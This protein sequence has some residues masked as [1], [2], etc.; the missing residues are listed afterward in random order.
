[1][2][3]SI[4]LAAF[5]V[6][7][8]MALTG[9]N[10]NTEPRLNPMP[11]GDEFI[12]YTPAENNYTYDLTNPDNTIILT[13]SGQ[14]DYGVAV[15]TSYEVQVSL[16]NTWEEGEKDENGDY[17]VYPTYY[18]L[19]TVNTQ[20]MVTASAL[21]LNQAITYLQGIYNED[22][23]NDYDSSVRPLWV[24]VLAYVST[25]S[26]EEGYVPYTAVMSNVVKINSVQPG[27][28][29]AL[30]LPGNLYIIGQYQGWSIDGNDQT[31]ALVETDYA[32][33]VYTGYMP[34]SAFE[35]TD[36]NFR[37]YSELGNWDTNSYGSQVDDS[38]VEVELE[39]ENGDWIYQDKCVKGKGSWRITNYPGD[40]WLF[41]TVDIK[42][43]TVNFL[44]DPEYTPEN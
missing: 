12:L 10:E 3:K 23:V 30:R 9:C 4:F 32:T 44:Y 42:N 24:R 21:E 18:S 43:M 2:K 8:G 39:D 11:D 28:E 27:L 38:P 15:P 41:I 16:D 17:I 31:I 40:G 33:K 19:P 1:M 6:M 20:S 14:P 37:F 5:A 29:A 13:T 22:Q 25:S 26:Y 7:A 35:G 36:K 34:A